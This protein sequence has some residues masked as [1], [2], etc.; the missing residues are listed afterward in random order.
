MKEEILQKMNFMQYRI[1]VFRGRVKR[2]NVTPHLFIKGFKVI[3]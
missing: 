2:N 3:F 1:V